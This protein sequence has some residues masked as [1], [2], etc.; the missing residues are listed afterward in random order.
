VLVNFFKNKLFFL[1]S[2]LMALFLHSCKVATFVK[3]Y[4]KNRPFIFETKI[5]VSGESITKEEKTR[6][7]ITLSGQ[8]DDSLRNKKIDKLVYSV[9]KKPAALDSISIGKSIQ[10]MHYYLQGEG[11]FN[12]SIKYKILIKPKEHQQRTYVTFNVFPGRVTRIDPLTYTLHDDSL[13]AILN[14]SL[15][16]AII[17]K[18]HPFAQGSISSELSRMVELYQNSGYLKFAK[19]ML[20]GLWDTLDVSLLQPS[21]DPLEQAQ[22][23]E[24]LRLRKLNPTVNL[25]IRLRPVDDIS[26]I[27][28]YFIGAITVYPDAKADSIGITPI[29]TTYKNVK[30]VQY[31]NKFRPSVFPPNIYMKFGDVYSQRRYLRTLNRFNSL[32]SWSSV[33]IVYDTVNSKGDT[34][35]F[36]LRLIPAKKYKFTAN[37]EGSFS[38]SVISGNFLGTGLNV[39]L[40]NRNFMH[41][42]NLANL[43]LRYGLELAIGSGQLVQTKQVSASGSVVYPRFIFPVAEKFKE[44]FKGTIRS[45]LNVNAAN[46][47]RRY[48]FNLTTVNGSWGYEFVRRKYSLGVKLPNLEYSYLIKRDSLDTLIKNNPSI[49]NIFSDGFIASGIVNFTYPWAMRNNKIVNVFRANMEESGLLTGLIPSKFLDDQLYRFIK[50]DAEYA[51]LVK[52]SKSSLVLRGFAGIGYEFDFTKSSDKRNKLPFF[53]QY[54][55]GGPNSMRAWLLRRLGPGS[56]VQS[57]KGGPTSVPDRFG[58]VQLEANIE[59]RANLFKIAGIPFNGALF[60]DV[61]NVWLLKSSAG[62]ESGIFKLSKLGKDIAIGSGA[63]IRIDMGFLVIRFDYGYK[64]KDPS[65]SPE[66]ASY[67]NKFFAYPFFKGSQLQI[68]IGY[69]FL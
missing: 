52:W 8:L 23:L 56:T 19:D 63:G 10:F 3:G 68:G 55:S 29:V 20:Y 58:D 13:Q 38:Q 41:R 54:Y 57:F 66:Y 45:M 21:F 27:R 34:A 17:K 25:D 26:R 4:P 5:K 31:N 42:A 46:T 6:L 43:N 16:S 50:L 12:D 36:F 24:I 32:G 1:F 49:K 14:K 37:A 18:G 65:P 28:K 51:R 40:Q 48:L 15:G 59:Y 30:V 2:I 60:T 22:Q 64:V 62:D 67:Q 69:P 61:G 39:G 35:A 11:Y 44:D 33:D 7:E 53:K 9:L 47:E